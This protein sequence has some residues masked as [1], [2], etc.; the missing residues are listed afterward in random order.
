MRGAE[1]PNPDEKEVEETF[2]L[3]RPDG[4]VINTKT[5]RIILLE[6]KRC[7]DTS[8]AYYTDMKSIAE[9]QHT[10]I[11]E[12]L[13]A[14]PEERGWMLEVLPLVV[15]QRWVR[16]KEWLEAMTMFGISSQDG[17]KIIYRLVSSLSSEHEK[18]FG[19]YLRQVF[20]PPSS[21]MHLLGKGL[22][23]RFINFP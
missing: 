12:G 4:W 17:K 18:L 19:S 6:F 21:L 2:R 10:P 14:L 7:S 22:S 20:G 3:S 13:N 9:R 16:E 11:L 8:E 5:N 15:V 1:A 23:V